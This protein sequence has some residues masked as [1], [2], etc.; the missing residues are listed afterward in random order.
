MTGSHAA[1]TPL[2]DHVPGCEMSGTHLAE[3]N[4]LG[5]KVHHGDR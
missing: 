5:G 4:Q 2:C 3:R 1:D